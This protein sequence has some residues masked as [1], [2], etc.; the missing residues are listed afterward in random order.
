MLGV[1]FSCKECIYVKNMPNTSG[2]IS[3]R[4]FIAPQDADVVRNMR[5]AG[6][7]LT[8]LTN[9]SE[10][11]MWLESSNYLFGTTCN[12]YNLSRFYTYFR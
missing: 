8:C 4:D 9:V 2:L 10:A 11:C 1:P 6:A 12:P 7:I 5:Q 3:R